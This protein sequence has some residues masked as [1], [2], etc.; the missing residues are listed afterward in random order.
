LDFIIGLIEAFDHI[1]AVFS[2]YGNF[3]LT[4]MEDALGVPLRE[5]GLSGAAETFC[6]ALVPILSLIAVW[7]FLRGI[8]RAVFVIVLVIFAIHAAAP[9][10]TQLP[11]LFKQIGSSV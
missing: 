3:L 5:L 9:L 10:T 1:V 6:V 4:S 7:R 11:A 8:I 2:R